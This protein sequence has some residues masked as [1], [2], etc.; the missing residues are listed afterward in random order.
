MF[1]VWNYTWY[2]SIDLYQNRYLYMHVVGWFY[3]MK[4]VSQFATLQLMP[5][6]PNH[7]TY[8]PHLADMWWHFAHTVT[9]VRKIII[10]GRLVLLCVSET[11]LSYRIWLMH[12]TTVHS[13]TITLF[14]N[15]YLENRILGTMCIGTRNSERLTGWHFEEWCIWYYTLFI[16]VIFQEQ[17]TLIIIGKQRYRN[18]G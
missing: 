10:I 11:S 18:D 15:F 4:Q 12:G 8:I 7:S 2:Q 9:I 17:K 14:M 16:W 13:K 6:D 5:S 1:I 3:K